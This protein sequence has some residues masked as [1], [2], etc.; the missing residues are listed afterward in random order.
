[1]KPEERRVVQAQRDLLRGARALLADLEML[2]EDQGALAGIEGTLDELFLLVIVGEYN[3]GK[4]TLINALLGERILEVGD[5]PTT[6]EVHLLKHGDVRATVQAEPGLLQH[7][8]PATLL[9]E[10]CVVDTPGTNSMQRREQD[11]AEGF[12]PRAD[13]VL[14]LTTLVRPYAAS[15]HDFLSFIRDWGKKILFVVNHADLARD[16]EQ[17]ERV[18]GYVRDQA[19]QGL[20]EESPVFVVSAREAL[21]GNVGP[22]NEWP[23]LEAHL[24]ETLAERPRIRRKLL[25][26]L[27]TLR[28][29]L[30][31]QREA[32]A[33]RARLV[34]GD[35][36]AMDKL[37]GDA[38][39]YE[40][41]MGKELSRYQGSI[42]N[43]LLQL[44]RR[45]HRFL[46]DHVRLGNLLRLR[47]ADIL[48]NRFRNDVVADTA[49]RVEEEVNALVDWLV[50]ENLAAW[51]RARETLEERRAALREAA[52]RTRLVPRETVYN[53][54][55]I[56]KNLAEPVK[57]R[58]KTFDARAEADRVVSSVNHA[59]ARTLGVEALV[60]GVGAVLTA[61]FTSL[62]IDVTGTVAG[63][64][65]VLAG[66]F[67]LPHR[68]A[69][70]KRELSGK[71]ETL[72]SELGETIER[73]FRE[74]T[75]RY[76]A[77]LRDVFRPERD[78][79]VAR[80]ETLAA[81]RER[82]ESL[83]RR[84]TELIAEVE[85]LT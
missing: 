25:S 38:D 18:R 75:R 60:A 26:P 21:E 70:L 14:F 69:R 68:R 2:P 74:E 23:A 3:A 61:A 55:E 15:E 56:F 85:A 20:G 44:E 62:T 64:M 71:I 36:V 45:G 82:L 73:S 72:R 63:T 58:L 33:E 43:V 49:E 46:D 28:P 4:S 77:Q 37:L 1:M 24:R 48:E 10:L 27:E 19:K 29:V 65:V 57:R 66:L 13:F 54:E 35:R 16:D 79:A 41:R 39:D 30:V 7:T 80:A 83:E 12:V 78:A 11:L 42:E 81:A 50:R 8:L 22:R 31:R 34:E 9:R 17:I 53:R 84:R 51:D 59:I 47:D 76:A 52:E 67:L 40:Q 5:L 32:L 6:R